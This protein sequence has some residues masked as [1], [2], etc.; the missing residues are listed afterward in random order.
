MTKPTKK[1]KGMHA[2]DTNRV[3]ILENK[4]LRYSADTAHDEVLRPGK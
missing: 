1:H 3:V 4:I 2:G